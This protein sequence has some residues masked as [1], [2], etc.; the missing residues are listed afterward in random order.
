MKLTTLRW[1]AL[2]LLLGTASCA[3]ADVAILL[4]EPYSYDGAF[5]GTGHAAVYLTRV[6]AA[7][8]TQLR[9]CQP[10]EQGVVLSRYH[11]IGGY[12][13]L[14]VPL[15]PY[16]YA[17]EKPERIPLFLDTKLEAALRDQYRRKYL[18]S[19]VPDEK[20]GEAPGGDWYELVGSAY[21]RT[22]YG[23]QIETSAG[24]DD[25]FIA[26]YNA[27]PNRMSYKLVSA[28]CAD[29]VREAI[30]FYYPK[31]VKR[32]LIADFDVS[33][34]KHAAKSLVQFSK[35]NSELQ[36]TVFVIPQVPGTIRR[37]RPV[38]GL[39]ES[40]FKA[41]KYELPLLALHPVVGGGLAAA[42]L[43][44]GRFN[45][46]QNALMFSPDGD[47]QSPITAQQR[48]DYMKGLEE[49]TRSNGE[50]DPRREEASWHHL[51]EDAQLQLDASGQPV[52]QVRSGDTLVEVGITRGNVLNSIAPREVTQEL[53]VARLREQLR[54]G[55]APKTSEV[56]LRK[57]WELLK[58]AFADESEGDAIERNTPSGPDALETMIVATPSHR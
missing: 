24:Q 10:G 17:V 14:A 7:S 42:Y 35:R 33:T 26:A 50:A 11:R 22:L 32:G 25:R 39:V 45:P 6:C 23:F 54:G 36:F 41:K 52:L 31:A 3:R 29:F 53:I 28:N 2:L 47:W 37:S 55:R 15:Y 4:E 18:E 1:L 9:R 30:N 13:W 40:V 56:E 38:R 34:P 49:V 16:L 44:G 48:R 21:D 27:R 20:S 51:L 58:A 43:A 46:S 19:I 5:A 8:P 57:D 12:D